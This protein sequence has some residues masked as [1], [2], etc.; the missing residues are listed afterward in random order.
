ML[1]FLSVWFACFCV[2]V[3]VVADAI[4]VVVI[5]IDVVGVIR[6]HISVFVSIYIF[7][8]VICVSPSLLVDLILGFGTSEL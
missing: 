3:F 1:L 8:I 7:S 5:V 6:Y 2:F 4:H